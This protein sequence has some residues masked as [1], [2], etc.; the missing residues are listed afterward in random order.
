MV[1]VTI[2]LL[3]LL[4]ASL[5]AACT[6]RNE[7]EID[8]LEM[9]Y[10]EE[11]KMNETAQMLYFGNLAQGRTEILAN[12]MNWVL[13]ERVEDFY[14]RIKHDRIPYPADCKRFY[15]CLSYKAYLASCPP[16]FTFDWTIEKC[17]FSYF[18]YCYEPVDEYF[19]CP[20]RNENY[21]HNKCDRYWLCSNGKAIQRRCGRRR[22]FSEKS[23][24]CVWRYYADCV[25]RPETDA[26]PG[27]H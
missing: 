14:C 16:M 12:I 18:A 23:R 25:E 27:Q 1:T 9:K 5:P 17:V 21:R 13:P 26:K 7:Q 6:D 24:E 4:A 15:L 3:L 11:M 22:F 20:E 2:V 19:P 8:R 10:I